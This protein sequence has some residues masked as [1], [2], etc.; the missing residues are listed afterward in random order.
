[1]TTPLSNVDLLTLDSKN[2]S[3]TPSSSSIEEEIHALHAEIEHLKSLMETVS[4]P[5]F[6]TC[7]IT[8]ND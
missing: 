6:G 1:M 3:K 2:P 5:S 7:S 8:N 4:K